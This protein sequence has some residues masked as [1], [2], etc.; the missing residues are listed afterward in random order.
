MAYIPG[1][2]DTIIIQQGCITCSAR[3]IGALP[4]SR[5][6]EYLLEYIADC[7]FRTINLVTGAATC[8]VRWRWALAG[9]RVLQGLLCCLLHGPDPRVKLLVIERLEEMLRAGRYN[10]ECPK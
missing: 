4:V 3:T 8:E 5:Y 6:A 1:V 2:S 7:H 10:L 9:V